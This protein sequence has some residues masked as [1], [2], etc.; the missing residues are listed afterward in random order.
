[1]LKSFT[2]YEKL[3]L[4]VAVLGIS[5]ITII[6]TRTSLEGDWSKLA[7]T[8]GISFISAI[9]GILTVIFAAKGLILTFYAGIIQASTYAYISFQWGLFG[10]SMLNAGFFLPLQF[11]GLWLWSKNKKK[12]DERISGEDVIAKRLTKK[13]IFILIPVAL[14]AIVI[15]AQV[16]TVINAQQ[17]RLDSIAVVLSVFAQILMTLRYAE[18]WLLWIIINILTITMWVITLSASP[19]TNDWAI[20]AMWIA[21]LINSIYGYLNWRKISK[22]LPPNSI[23]ETISEET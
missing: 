22:P 16:L 23:D 10:E 21:F 3:W 12:K 19:V 14:I 20:L 1:M 17:I 6:T 18:Q 7:W 5:I 9:A 15:Y 11:V 2:L 4:I 13:Q 8:D